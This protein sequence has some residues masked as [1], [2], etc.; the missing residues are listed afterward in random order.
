MC[1]FRP[2]FSSQLL[3]RFNVV[4]VAVRRLC[5]W[6]ANSPERDILTVNKI[7]AG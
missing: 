5:V 3:T 6:V 2:L 7:C 1:R 4:A